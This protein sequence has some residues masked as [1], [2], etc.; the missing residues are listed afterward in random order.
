MRKEGFQF[1]ASSTRSEGSSEDKR[2]ASEERAAQ[3][4]AG[5]AGSLPGDQPEAE[6][7]IERL[8]AGSF[9]VTCRPWRRRAFTTAPELLAWLGGEILDSNHCDRSIGA[10]TEPRAEPEASAQG[11][12]VEAPRGSATSEKVEAGEK[13]CNVPAPSSEGGQIPGTAGSLAPCIHFRRRSSDGRA[14]A[15]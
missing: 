6:Y 12:G 4:P 1:A 14:A 11:A 2:P 15:L 8:D 9:L 5:G 13:A 3:R 10:G 7:R